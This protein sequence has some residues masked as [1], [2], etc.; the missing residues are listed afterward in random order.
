M[1][2]WLAFTA[3]SRRRLEAEFEGLA[4]WLDAPEALWLHRPTPERW[5]AAEIVEHVALAN[6][7]L[8]LLAEK[9]AT[10]SRTRARRGDRAP[11]TP[12]ELGHLDALADREFRWRHPEHMTPTGAPSRVE[13]RE[14]L[15][16]QRALLLPWLDEFGR[17][18][19][20]LHRIRISVVAGDDRLDL[21]QLL[22]FIALHI[23]RH[24]AQLERNADDFKRVPPS[25][26]A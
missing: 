17:G 19:G 9:I 2:D 24:R 7:F 10:K 26:G 16:A 20:A 1:N 14:R 25:P 23:A 18:E 13:L 12:S 22:H 5:S 15:A 21:Y 11:E 6:H 3:A 8:S 4:V